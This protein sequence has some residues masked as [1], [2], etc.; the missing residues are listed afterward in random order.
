MPPSVRAGRL[1]DILDPATAVL[2][3][4]DSSGAQPALLVLRQ[5]VDALAVG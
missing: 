2:E 1:V 5:L 4:V 3:S